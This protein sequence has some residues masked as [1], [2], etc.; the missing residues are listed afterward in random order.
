MKVCKIDN[1]N[2][3]SKAL[4]MCVNHYSKFKRDDNIRLKKY[5]RLC[6]M[7]NGEHIYASKDM[8]IRAKT[9]NTMC[10]SCS[11]RK[12]IKIFRDNNNGFVGTDNPFFGQKH[13]K[14]T[15]EILK[16]VDKSYTKTKEFSKAVIIGMD[17]NFNRK[18]VYDCW[19]DRY[20]K[21]KADEL[22]LE[23]S[24][25]K[26]IAW[27]GK[28]N[29][30]YGKP[31]P[32][33]SGNGW[34]GWY[35]GIF[36]RSIMELSYMVYLDNNDIIYTIAET[37]EYRVKYI[38]VNGIDKYYF[39]DFVLKDSSNII[40]VKPKRLTNTLLNKLK[41]K[42]AKLKYV[43]KFKIITEDDIPKLCDDEIKE[44]YNNKVIVFTDRYEQKYK[45][46]FLC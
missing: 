32:P 20:G 16:N 9:K 12:N 15:L 6:P 41:F 27:R 2:K 1:C 28:N 46:K 7:C 29:P 33:G 19:V 38:D 34:S 5:V 18:P 37:T 17:G 21:E 31:S 24:R 42:A 36:F 22:Q 8:F 26:S 14:H 39:P 44:L 11:G 35:N 4:E 43:D 23:L 25:K 10:S 3:K 40:E 30:M 45:D 13:N